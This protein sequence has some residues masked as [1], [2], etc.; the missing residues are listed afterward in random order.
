MENNEIKE[1]LNIKDNNYSE[2]M[3]SLMRYYA[4]AKYCNNKVVVDVA[5]GTGYG[6]YLLAKDAK[7]VYGIDIDENV[8]ND[9]KEKYHKENLIFKVGNADN[10]DLDDKTVDILVSCETVE[11]IT[12]QQF[13]KFLQ[14]N[15]RIL[16]KNGISFI[17]TPNLNKTKT[18]SQKN[19]YHINEMSMEAFEEKLK[20]YFK[21][22]QIYCLD[23]NIVTYM[24]KVDKKSEKLLNIQV[25]HWQESDSV[26][27]KTIYMAAICS[28]KP[29]K[30]YDI[31]S[32][33]IDENKTLN[34]M[35]WNKAK[36]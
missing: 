36:I 24:R 30:K 19:P 26:E 34:E 13:E 9:N 20:K 2:I 17:T 1:R 16:K 27:P 5:C 23:L 28:N 33:L 14:E 32:V 6:S 25:E 11:H 4:I 21:Y 8:I 3:F 31:S 18:F 35:L 29:I 15:I 12:D 7:R 22:V 10:I